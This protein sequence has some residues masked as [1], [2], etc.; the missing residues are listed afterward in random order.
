[1]GFMRAEW[2]YLEPPSTRV[3]DADAITLLEDR[4]DGTPALLEDYLSLEEMTQLLTLSYKATCGYQGPAENAQQV[5]HDFFKRKRDEYCR[6][7]L[8][9]AFEELEERAVEEAMQ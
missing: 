4:I 1:M 9:E 3:D 8:E 7:N 2:A 6:A 5:L